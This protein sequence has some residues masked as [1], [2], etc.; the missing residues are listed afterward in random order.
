MAPLS[1]ASTGSNSSGATTSTWAWQDQTPD[2]SRSLNGQHLHYRQQGGG[3]DRGAGCGTLQHKCS[4]SLLETCRVFASVP[5][6]TITSTR[7]VLAAF[8][9][10]YSALRRRESSYVA[11]TSAWRA[12]TGL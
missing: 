5:H 10:D 4:D 6:E 12:R 2:R 11:G 1:A 3:S 7:Q 8:N 9:Y